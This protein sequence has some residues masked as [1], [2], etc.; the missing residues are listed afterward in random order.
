MELEQTRPIARTAAHRVD[1]VRRLM[2]YVYL[3][4]ALIFI[5]AFVLYPLM[6]AV[7]ISFHQWRLVGPPPRW[8]GLENYIDILTDPNFGEIL[9]H[10]GLYLLF[11]LVGSF[12]LPV[13]LALM[14]LQLTEREVD[15]F[16][17]TLFLPTVIA[18]NIA[19]TI[20]M[21]FYLPTGG[22]FN[23]LLKDYFNATAPVQFLASPASAL[24]SV[25]VAANWKVIG[26]HFLLA[27]AGLKAIPRDYLEAAYVDGAAGWQ[28]VRRIIL[29]LFAPTLLFLFI[30]TLVQGLD[31]VFTPIEVMTSGGPAGATTHLMY[32]IF[33]EGFRFFRA[34][35]AAAMS[36]ILIVLYSGLIFFQFRLFERNIQ[37][38][39]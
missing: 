39:R 20:W 24:P 34:G 7:F 5:T 3:A 8:V 28:L 17:S 10:S 2:P 1:W 37:Y 4:P 12:L 29:P 32:A 38:D 18:A 22:L 27:L 30:I 31:N 14:T 21:Y 16:Q 11:A 6:R 26:F 9:L 33:Q 25:A 23:E 36:V 19:M 35:H 13:G 15:L